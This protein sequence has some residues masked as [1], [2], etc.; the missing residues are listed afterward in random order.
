M[1]CLRA[2]KTFST[3]ISVVP[4][5]WTLALQAGTDTGLLIKETYF[6]LVSLVAT[7]HL[8]IFGTHQMTSMCDILTQ[9]YLLRRKILQLHPLSVHNAVN[10]RIS[11]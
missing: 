5:C 2:E 9:P 1:C 7:S 3:S 10:I 8:N 6:S 4:I 11:H